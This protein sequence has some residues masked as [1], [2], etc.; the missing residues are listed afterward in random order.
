MSPGTSFFH[1]DSNATFYEN[2]SN[3]NFIIIN[4]NEP[5]FPTTS[6]FF[7]I[8]LFLFKQ[9]FFSSTAVQGQNN[10]T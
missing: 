7:L 10:G 5:T 3:W 1:C 2:E 6:L 4:F 9:I 8:A